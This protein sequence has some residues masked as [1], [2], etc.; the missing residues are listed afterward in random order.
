MGYPREDRR[1][2]RQRRRN[3]HISESGGSDT[4]RILRRV[5][6]PLSLLAVSCSLN[7][8]P[9]VQPSV[10]AQLWEPPTDIAQRDLFWGSGG[11]K[12]APD[13]DEL[14]EFKEEKAVGTQ[15]GYDVEDSKGREWSVK[16]GP[17]ARPEVAVSRLVW[18]AGYRQPSVYYLPRWTLVR[19]GKRIPQ[20]GRSEEHTSELQS[21][22]NL[23]CR[24]LLE[25][26]KKKMCV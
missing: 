7:E 26:K 1:R 14:Y 2:V 6:L 19:D 4:M 13:P 12:N 3:P 16:L 11:Q 18:A 10:M 24:L 23:V 8:R 25:K 9:T 17:E 15:P 20:G 5:A 22:C 21:P